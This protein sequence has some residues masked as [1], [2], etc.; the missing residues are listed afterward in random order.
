[1]LEKSAEPQM[2]N[3]IATAIG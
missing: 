3:Y 2:H 1:M